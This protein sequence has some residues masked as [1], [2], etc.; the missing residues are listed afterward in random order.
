MREE[1]FCDT[2][3]QWET[4]FKVDSN[5]GPLS[6][7]KGVGVIYGRGKRGGIGWMKILIRGMAGKVMARKTCLRDYSGDCVSLWML[8]RI[9]PCALS[10]TPCQPVYRM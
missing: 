8:V 10:G 1:F 3:V 5:C 7:W 2:F 9:H 6:F 4:L